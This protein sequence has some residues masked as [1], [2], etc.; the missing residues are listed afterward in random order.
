MISQ[1]I[2]ANAIIKFAICG[3][4][5]SCSRKTFDSSPGYPSELLG[6]HLCVAHYCNTVH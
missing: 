3:H 1:S 6:A 5:L 4:M 2:V